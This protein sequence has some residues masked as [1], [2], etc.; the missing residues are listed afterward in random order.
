MSD[1]EYYILATVQEGSESR[2]SKL[3]I[4][5]SI[6]SL[7]SNFGYGRSVNAMFTVSQFRVDIV[8]PVLLDLSTA[9]FQITSI[10][11]HR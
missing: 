7:N 2:K 4:R 6:S 3:I 1:K 8:S 5:S 10:K 9:E 11:D